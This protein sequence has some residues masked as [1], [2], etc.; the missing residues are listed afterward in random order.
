VSHWNV[1]VVGSGSREHT[2]AWK[3]RQSPRVDHLYCAPGNGGTHAVAENVPIPSNELD[4]ITDWAAANRIDLVV[5]GPEE[6]LAL[7]LADRLKERGIPVLGPTADAARIESS[8]RWAKELMREAGVPTASYAV[9][10]DPSAAWQY[11]RNQAYPLAVKA[12]GLAAG[13]GVVIAQNPDEARAAITASLEAG[14]FGEAGRTLVIE[15]FLEGDEVSLI[16]FVDGRTVA[17]LA[18]ARDHKRIGDGDTGPNTGGMGAIAP[19]RLLDD[20]GADRLSA[21]IL[22]PIAQALHERGLTYRGVI[23]AGLMLTKSGPRVIEFNCRLGDPEAQVILPLLDGD[24]AEIAYATASG[25]LRPGPLPTLPGYR[26]GVVVASD[27]YPGK[28]R[29][30][31]PI[32]GVDQVDPDALV[33][34]AGTKRVDGSLVTAGGRVMT[35][36]GRGD[37][38]QGAREHAYRNVE[39]IRFDGAY[40]RHDIGLSE[41]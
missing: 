8:K 40:C 18:L 17:R 13:K 26:C 15:E 20:V 33:F 37:T 3:L 41:V 39:R 25:E 35:V 21:T 36:V 9:F 14:A 10:Q 31:L 28:Y 22:E 12:D 30:G 29:T 1:L 5:V 7:G 23:F 32:E 34:H 16:A 24:L 2:V 27:G 38:L 19:S 11:A 6:P 4:A